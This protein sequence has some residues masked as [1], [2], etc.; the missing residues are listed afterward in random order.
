MMFY[1]EMMF[2]EGERETERQRERERDSRGGGGWRRERG[3]LDVD[4]AVFR[5]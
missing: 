3:N 5:G 1:A 2:R 4:S